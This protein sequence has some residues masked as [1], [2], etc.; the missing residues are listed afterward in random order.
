ML[1][2]RSRDG[3][4]RDDLK[5]SFS[6]GGKPHPV[7]KSGDVGVCEPPDSQFVTGTLHAVNVKTDVKASFD[8]CRTVLEKQ[9]SRREQQ[10]GSTTNDRDR[11]FFAW[12][13]GDASQ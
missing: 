6:F 12:F 10:A 1:T 11:N 2:M 9:P 7:D 4:W 13:P 8:G 5:I 3:S